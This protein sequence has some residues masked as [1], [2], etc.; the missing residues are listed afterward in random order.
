MRVFC[1]GFVVMI[2]VFIVL[3]SNYFFK[4]LFFLHHYDIS[5][6]LLQV[7]YKFALIDW[8]TDWLIIFCVFAIADFL[9][10]LFATIVL[11][12]CRAAVAAG[13]AVQFIS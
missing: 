12:F 11:R 2:I 13:K 4:L 3:Y 10:I 5:H 7:L 8:L 6:A 9:T 1:N